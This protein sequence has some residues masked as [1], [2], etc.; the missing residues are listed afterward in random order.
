ME[1]EFQPMF[2]YSAAIW[3]ICISKFRYDEQ[4][5]YKKNEIALKLKDELKY[6]VSFSLLI[7]FHFVALCVLQTLSV[8]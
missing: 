2:I 3:Q 4:H 6:R 7:L 8:F 1:V 5:E